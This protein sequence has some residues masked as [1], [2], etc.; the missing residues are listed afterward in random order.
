MGEIFKGLMLEEFLELNGKSFRFRR[1]FFW[2][3]VSWIKIALMR[4][5]VWELWFIKNWGCNSF[6]GLG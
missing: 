1:F 6:E 3:L 4:I 5:Y 2:C